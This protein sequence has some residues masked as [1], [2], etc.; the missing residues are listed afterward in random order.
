M[1]ETWRFLDTGPCPAAFNLALDESIAIA[2][3][4]GNAPP[5][6]RLYSWQ[7]PSVSIGY[8]QKIMDIDT[9]YCA[10]KNIPV[11]RRLTGGRAILHDDEITYSFSAR[12]VSGS[13]SGGLLD[14]Y[15]KISVAFA[16]ALSK[17]GIPPELKL[18]RRSRSA[19]TSGLRTKSPSCFQ[20]VSY[21]EITIGGKKVIGSAQKRWADALLQ[22]GA[23]PLAADGVDAMKVFRLD[24]AQE[25][26]DS[27]TGLH[28]VLPNFIYEDF[29]EAVRV[30]FEETL[31]GSFDASSLFPEEIST[32]RKLQVEKYSSREWNFRR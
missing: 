30:S 2:V 18:V 24:T 31:N 28:N 3:R 32:A 8:F 26:N 11:I 19:A 16:L 15:R 23:I 29:K 4:E 10:E 7:T 17:I 25:I 9:G 6:L 12:T 1:T 13:F 5:T 20:S 27:F 21:G 14:S 22:Q